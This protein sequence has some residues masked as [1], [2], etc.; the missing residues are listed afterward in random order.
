MSEGAVSL[1]FL[2]ASLVTTAASTTLSVASSIQQG[3]VAE[4]VAENEAKSAEIEGQIA[5]SAALEDAA[6]E[7][8]ETK[9]RLSAIRHATGASGVEV[10]SGSSLLAFND[11]LVEGIRATRT[12]QRGGTFSRFRAKNQANVSRFKG[13]AARG[14]SLLSGG[15]S[16]LRGANRAHSTIGSAFA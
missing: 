12:I 15:A 14:A 11:Q 6:V 1:P 4:A 8:R 16:A 10:G 2:I 3:K 5:A 9:R 7:K 13:R